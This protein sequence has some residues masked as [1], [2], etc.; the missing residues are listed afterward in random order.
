[1]ALEQSELDQLKGFFEQGFQAVEKRILDTVAGQ[2]ADVTPAPADRASL[3]GKPDVNPEAG[4][5][6]Y[7]HL[8]DGSVVVT[9]DS[10]STHMANA[11]G[12]SVA[13]IGRYQKGE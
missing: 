7:V 2:I 12:E 3:V 11:D 1:M 13:V 9:R 10:A 6:Y 5:E 8:A 4:P